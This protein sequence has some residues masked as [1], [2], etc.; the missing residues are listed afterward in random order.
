LLPLDAGA[1]DLIPL[2]AGAED[3][4]PLDAGAEH[5]GFMHPDG[6]DDD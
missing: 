3:L 1:K 5:L 4:I 6:T 2:D